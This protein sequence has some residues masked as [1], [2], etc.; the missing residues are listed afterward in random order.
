MKDRHHR[1]SCSLITVV[2]VSLA[3][4][5]CASPEEKA[6]RYYDRDHELLEKRDYA[7]AGIELRYALQLK[8]NMVEAWRGLLQVELHTANSQNIAPILQN[9]VELD[10]K[11]IEAEL[12]LGRL[13][14][15]GGAV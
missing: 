14:L 8:K 6:Q 15:A 3:L 2:L 10:P 9:I 4:A 13:F 12:R 5:A 1:R 11:D 7:K